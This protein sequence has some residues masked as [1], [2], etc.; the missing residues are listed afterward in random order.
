MIVGNILAPYT[1]KDAYDSG[2]YPSEV[3]GKISFRTI[4][5]GSTDGKITSTKEVVFINRDGLTVDGNLVASDTELSKLDVYGD[6]Y[7]EG[8]LEADTDVKISGDLSVDKIKPA[9]EKNK[10]SIQTDFIE[11]G[12]Y[13][14]NNN[15]STNLNTK[16]MN[17]N[18]FGTLTTTSSS[19]SLATLDIS[20]SIFLYI[21]KYLKSSDSN[22]T[23]QRI[24]SGILLYSNN[25]VHTMCSKSSDG[26]TFTFEAGY[27]GK[28]KLSRPS[29]D[30][31]NVEIRVIELSM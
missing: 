7:I 5:S 13:R 29:N 16:I 3:A 26:T 25:E 15:K 17:E 2:N 20:G 1:S 22:S 14:T 19:I 4:D 9:G 28:L 30:L 10:I 31:K 12:S 23:Q 11:I 21:I 8:E 6:T 18:E 24:A 27:D